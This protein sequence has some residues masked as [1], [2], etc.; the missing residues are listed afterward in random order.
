MWNNVLQYEHR[1]LGNAD[2]KY[3][4]LIIDV[5]VLN[6]RENE[7]SKPGHAHLFTNSLTSHTIATSLCK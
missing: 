4:A 3:R 1:V 2:T 5:W 7:L 6:I